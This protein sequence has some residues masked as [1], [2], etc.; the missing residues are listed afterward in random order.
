MSTSIQASTSRIPK[1]SR[2]FR[3]STAKWTPGRSSLASM[4]TALEAWTI[5]SRGCPEDHSQ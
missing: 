1:T 4:D 2:T 5:N 3:I